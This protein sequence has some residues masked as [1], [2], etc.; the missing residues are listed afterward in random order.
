[1]G[2]QRNCARFKKGNRQACAAIRAAPGEERF[3]ALV[4]DRR[5]LPF[6]RATG[7]GAITV[8]LT[9]GPARWP[10]LHFEAQ[11]AVSLPGLLFRSGSS[12]T[13]DAR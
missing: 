10:R 5:S 8:C 12:V 6:G 1:M 3:V 4:L 7:P 9:P 2:A 13:S 11:A